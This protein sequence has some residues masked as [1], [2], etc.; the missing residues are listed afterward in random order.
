MNSTFKRRL[1]ISDGIILVAATAVSLACVREFE[2]LALAMYGRQFGW[3]RRFQ[4]S[5]WAA[6]PL[7]LA[8]IPLRLR[9]PRPRRQL[10]WRQPGWL[11]VI[12][13]AV[14]FAHLLTLVV[15][16]EYFNGSLKARGSGFLLR[17]GALH[18]PTKSSCSVATIWLAL[19]LSGR[20]RSEKSW[21][22]RAGRIL[23]WYWIM[24]PIMLKLCFTL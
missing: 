23:G 1:S 18:I 14:S 4:A 22:D 2:S 9:Q 8:L 21:I 6:L 16:D 12:A 17:T 7:T 15:L 11:A 20:W 3:A 13:V 24:Y 19:A 5:V 10:L